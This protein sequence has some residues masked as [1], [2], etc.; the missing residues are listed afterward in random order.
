LVRLRLP[1]VASV[2]PVLPTDLLEEDLTP[3]DWVRKDL[4]ILNKVFG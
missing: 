2:G 3:G 1:L 4:P